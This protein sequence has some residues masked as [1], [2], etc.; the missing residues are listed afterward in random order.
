MYALQ[1]SEPAL[2][3]S[4]APAPISHSSNM[5]P[6]KKNE[7]KLAGAGQSDC[8]GLHVFAQKLAVNVTVS[9]LSVLSKC[10]AADY[11]FDL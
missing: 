5:L 7:R 8:W 3:L 9:K 4:N 1:T 11:T 2:T 6:K 10:T